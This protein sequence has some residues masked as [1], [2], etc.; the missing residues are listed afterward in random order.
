MLTDNTEMCSSIRA[1]N[2]YGYN[3]YFGRNRGLCPQMCQPSPDLMVR[4]CPSLSM[5]LHTQP[6]PSRPHTRTYTQ[7]S[8]GGKNT[9]SPNSHKSSTDI[10]QGIEREPEIQLRIKYKTSRFLLAKHSYITGEALASAGDL[11]K[12]P[13]HS[14]R[15]LV[16]GGQGGFAPPPH[17]HLPWMLEPGQH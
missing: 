10:I 6:S 14:A 7:Q 15:V 4:W 12:A 9:L 5:V 16:R 13:T 1:S 8:Q 11:G 17:P 2:H 3:S